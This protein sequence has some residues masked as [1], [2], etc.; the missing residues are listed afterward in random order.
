MCLLEIDLIMWYT[1]FMSENYIKGNVVKILYQS[2]TGYKVGLFK[3]KEAL[4]EAENYLN[5][6][7]TF[8]GNFMPLNNELTY[9]F[10]GYLINHARFGVQFN[11]TSYESVIPSNI[12]GLVMYLSSGIF[13]GIGPKTAKAIVDVFKEETISEIKNGNPVLAKIKGMTLKKASELTKKI[14]EYDKDQELILEFNKMGF[15]TEECLRIVNKYK[16]RCFDIIN[17]NIYLLENDIN[18]LKLDNV[19]L[20]MHEENELVRVNALIKY[21]IKNLCYETG[22]T[23]VSTDSVF[24]NVN[25]YFSESIS[26]GLFLNSLDELIS[27]DEVIK[28]NDMLTL[29]M[30]YSAERNI[31]DTVKNLLKRS[32]LISEEEINNRISEYEEKNKIKFNDEQKSAIKGS[33][34]N[35]FFIITGGPGTGKTTIIKAIVDIYEDMNFDTELEDIT[36][37]APTGRA[38]KRITESVKRK[39]ST[40]HKFLKW[41]KETKEFSVNRF[42]PSF[43]KLVIVDEASMID[44]FL[45]NSLLDALRENVKLILVGDKHQLPSIAPGNVLGDLLN[46]VEIPKIYLE[47]IYRT[48]KDSYIIP[49]ANQIKNKVMFNEVP[50]SYSDFKFINSPDILIKKYLE[51]VVTK[52]RDKKLNIDNFQVLIPMYKGENGIENINRLM[53]D[54]FNPRSMLRKEIEIKG[55]LYREGDKVLQLVNDVD[56]NIYNGDVGYIKRITLGSSPLIDIEYTDHVVNYKRGKFEEFTLAYAVSVHKSQGSEYDNVILV[57]PSNMKRMLYNKLIYTAV[58]RAKKS[59]VI[60][61]NLDSFNYSVQTD[62]SENRK[63]SL[64]SFF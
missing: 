24:L 56:N 60:I 38:S 6:T 55:T 45:F 57:M 9:K 14:N 47:E 4:G 48:K 37:L 1:L 63:T 3:V 51:E 36:L 11:V 46:I 27:N 33:L 21:V 10:T 54:I 49:L 29:E 15:T 2:S 20:K 34:I 8:T 17:N 40:I 50:S 26:S 59:L 12:D 23:I 61:G 53:Q 64:N 44:I 35:N 13:K 43:T 22:N 62:Y 42:N 28:V 18:F 58:T 52:A 30:F 32:T 25:K 7:L 41:N 16:S 39:S 5:K 19:F 31:A